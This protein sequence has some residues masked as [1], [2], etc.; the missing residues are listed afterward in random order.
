MAKH[1]KRFFLPYVLLLFVG[2][3][4]PTQAAPPAGQTWNLVWSDEFTNGTTLDTN[5]WGYGSTPW[6]AENQS[7]CTLSPPEDTYVGGGNL[8]N[9][10]RL[11]PFTGPS[12]TTYAYSSGWTWSKIWLAYGYLEI[13]AQYPNERGAWPAFWM[14]K[15]GWPPEIDIDEY[16]GTPKNYMTHALY[17]STS[18]WYSSAT[19]DTGGS[20]TGWHVY[21]LEWGPGYLKYY[22]DG[23]IQKTTTLS[24]VPSDPMYVI[25]S[26]GSDCTDSDG[27]GFPNYFVIDYFRWYQVPPTNVPV[28]PTSLAATDGSNQVALNWPAMDRAAGYNVKRAAVSGGTYATIATTTGLAATRYTDT[29]VINFTTYYYV[30]SAVNAIGQST[31]SAEADAMPTPPPISTGDPVTAS[32]FQTGHDPFYGNDGNSTT[33]WTASSGNYPQWWRVDL[34]SV[35]TIRKVVINWEVTSASHQYTIDVSS[36]DS[37]YITAVNKSGNTT[38]G[39]TADTF[40]AT[41]RYVRITVTGS[42]SG[43]ASLFECQVFGGTPPGA[44]SGLSATATSANQINLSWTA[45]SGATSYNLQR[46]TVSGGPYTSVAGPASTNYS[47]TGLTGGTTYYYAVSAV[48][49]G[50]QSTNSAQAGATTP[51]APPAPTGLNATAVSTNQINLNWTASSGATSYNVKSTTISGGSYTNV[52]TG[53]TTTGYTNTGLNAGTTYYY[54]VTAVN[55]NGESA[56]SIQT[57]NTTI[58]PAPAGLTATVIGMPVI[59]NWGA[60]AGAASYNIKRAPVSGG[61]YATIAAGITTMIYTNTGLQNGATYYYVVSAMNT[62]GESANSAEAGA[63]PAAVPLLLSQGGPATASTFQSGNVVANAN[64]GSLSTRW[65]AASGSYPQWWRVDLGLVQSINEVIIN[66]ENSANW[67]YKYRIEASNDDTNYTTAVDQTGR[68]A[69]GD[70]TN[71]FSAFARYVR[72]TVTGYSGSGNAWASI[73]ECQFFGGMPPAAPTGLSATV[74][75]SSQ[76]NLS[77]TASSGATSYNVKCAPV[78]GGPYT[79]MATGV[80]GL[81]YTNTGLL[82]GTTYYYVVSAVN[83]GGEGT[84]SPEVS[85]HLVSSVPPQ[86]TTGLNAGALVIAWPPGNTGWRLQSQT[87]GL[88]TN[89]T[90]VPGAPATNQMGLPINPASGAVFFRLIYP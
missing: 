76:V 15:S 68:T 52:A 21:G 16:R 73:Y 79:N 67:S 26:N 13:R 59:L 9:R 53:V 46:A 6:G 62:A 86:I 69:F 35:Q 14:L 37:T 42:S 48:N 10:S 27:T 24:T 56:N 7:A 75:S 11:G 22:I 89:W 78:S 80:G 33:R 57:G 65:T 31:N 58:P 50:G 43:W 77:W 41:G 1:M 39:N 23:V 85:A 45:G 8:T 4:F 17:D 61:P 2:T 25:L 19:G 55:G 87:N 70:S 49:A 47:D 36:N 71:V 20:F 84:S 82:N 64:D 40:T 12:G 51:T 72:V 28:T 74:V 3:L 32:S 90:D 38:V 66:W 54:V 5:L 63:T 88:G 81:S 60:T 30:V 44:P 18:T 29:N 83:A 34:G